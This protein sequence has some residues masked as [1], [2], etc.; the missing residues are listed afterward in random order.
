MSNLKLT[1]IIFILISLLSSCKKDSIEKT[2]FLQEL[3]T[4][5]YFDSE[6]F[7]DSDLDIYGKWKLYDI[8]GG[9]TGDGC[10]LILTTWK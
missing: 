1:F 7:A 4:T 3:E 6:I 5:K 9:I 8:S 2:S 10:D